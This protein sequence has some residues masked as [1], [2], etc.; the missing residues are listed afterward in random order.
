[1][2]I[3]QAER[4]PDA[5]DHGTTR[6]RSSRSRWTIGSSLV[7][8][9]RLSWHG[10]GRKSGKKADVSSGCST[11]DLITDIRAEYTVQYG[12]ISY[13]FLV[14]G[15]QLST[16]ALF[17]QLLNYRLHL[18]TQMFVFLLF[19]T[20]VYIIVNIIRASGTDAIDP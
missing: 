11:K 17:R 7:S 18:Q 2:V 5:L 14:S 3:L 15:L 10:A 12:C 20:V 9:L 13:I 8:V 1:M 4:R 16:H 6:S 19:P